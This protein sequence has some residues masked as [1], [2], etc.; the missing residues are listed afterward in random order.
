METKVKQCVV[1]VVTREINTN[2]KNVQD[3]L[4][5]H[6]AMHEMFRNY[7]NNRYPKPVLYNI[8]ED[9]L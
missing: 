4:K 9:K 2:D 5:V 3:A 8:S 1:E 6:E 7:T